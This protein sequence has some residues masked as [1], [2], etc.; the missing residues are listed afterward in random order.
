MFVVRYAAVAALAIWLGAAAIVA[1]G[2]ASPELLRCAPGVAYVC[3]AAIL[4]S[5]TIMKFVGP[6]PH[7]YALRAGLVS[8][9]IAAS[10]IASIRRT[11]LAAAAVNT[12]VGLV[13]LGW[14]A[15]E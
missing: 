8:L 6:P 10:A 5:L 9:M 3:G 12:G 7:A 14:Y 4:V 13:L 11:P 2:H 15:R 1:A